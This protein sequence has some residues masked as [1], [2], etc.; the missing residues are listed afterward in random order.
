MQKKTIFIR[1]YQTPV[2]EMV[3]GSYDGQ[4]CL[5]DWANE[6]RRDRIDRRL[7]KFFSA[8]M[9][10][11][12]SVATD[13]A[14]A[15]LEEYFLCKRTSFDQPLIFAGT[16][17]QKMVWYKLLDIPYGE[18][19]SYG[20]I[21]RQLGRPEAVRAVAN[22][23]GANAI[24]IFVP[25]HRVIGSNFKLVGYAGGP[26]AK[27]ALLS[28]EWGETDPHQEG[29]KKM[30]E[31]I[32]IA[33]E[34]HN[35]ICYSI[36]DNNDV[37][38]SSR[39]TWLDGDIIFKKAESGDLKEIL[40]LQ[41][42]AYRSEAILLDNF[43]IQPLMQTYDEIVDEFSGS[44]FYKAINAEKKI[45]GSIR[46]HIQDGTL[47]IGKLMV[48]PEKQGQG[49]GTRLLKHIESEYPFLRK[50]LFTSDLSE[51]NIT[52]YEKNGYKIFNKIPTAKGFDMIY[53]EK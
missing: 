39:G 47:H 38:K 10:E 4:L 50:E 45:I 27:K 12:K 46:G 33:K 35:H 3:L 2:G 17:F 6:A 1:H 32:I 18:T 37:L 15:E 20:E 48:S 9:V 40:D 53:L 28:L 30:M 26:D 19:M 14:I 13:M 36:S 43:T 7:R 8:E 52:L 25:C 24:S 21:A 31:T 11:G 34:A 44:V 51:K 23:I 49:I 29:R 22:A 16:D 5:C 41:Y 42:V